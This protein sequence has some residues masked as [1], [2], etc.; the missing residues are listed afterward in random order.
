MNLQD[1]ST[2]VQR[3]NADL[4]LKMRNAAQPGE[5]GQ[6]LKR[7]LLKYWMKKPDWIHFVDKRFSWING[8]YALGLAA[9][10]T[11]EAICMLTKFY[12]RLLFVKRLGL[13]IFE[14]P[15]QTIHAEVLLTLYSRYGKRR[16]RPLIRE[17]ADMLKTV[18][19][20]NDGF[21]VYWP[22]DR[23]ILVD[24]LGMMAGFCYS[25]SKA[26]GTDELAD[27]A[28]RQIKY[29]EDS[30]IDPESGYPF[31]SCRFT[32]GIQAG[33]STWGRG[34]GW[35][36]IGLTD[37]TLYHSDQKDRL[38]QVFRKVFSCQD[39][40]G[41]LYDD[42]K[43]P[44]HIDTSPTC[45]AA[46]CLAKCIQQGLF[47]EAESRSLAPFLAKSVR[48]LCRSVSESGEV[49]DCSGECR[50]PGA[51]SAEFGNYFSQGYTL[52]LFSMIERSEKLQQLIG[53]SKEED[54]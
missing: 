39:R 37:Y 23:E 43:Q 53:S 45:M 11:P 36:L 22:P 20:Q 54:T 33:S 6:F 21:A 28:D 46:L 17:A 31:H 10:G 12:D 38:L 50:G 26:F 35:Y 13:P 7:K 34:I 19:D 5:T 32:E 2:Y 51:Y 40:D 47:D 4:L 41:F 49:M 42:L 16:Y 14:V 29:T 48:A 30:V 18:A 27:I 15:D 24:T 1:I 8:Q 25:F 52:A 44:T 3:I 9:T